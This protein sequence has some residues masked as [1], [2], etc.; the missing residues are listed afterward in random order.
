MQSKLPESAIPYIAPT[1]RGLRQPV[2]ES[3]ETL[4][5]ATYRQMWT[6]KIATPALIPK[7]YAK[8][9]TQSTHDQHCRCCKLT[10]GLPK[11]GTVS[12]IPKIVILGVAP[13]SV[14]TN[15][16]FEKPPS[17]SL[18]RTWENRRPTVLL[19]QRVH[20]L[21]DLAILARFDCHRELLL[22]LAQLD[23]AA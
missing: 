23:V 19:P 16:R 12:S 22:V 17:A 15:Q 7:N 20:L 18:D 13:H 8:H 1:L 21:D 11:I 5:L 14:Q 3:Y 9:K 4:P 6:V 2:D 10:F